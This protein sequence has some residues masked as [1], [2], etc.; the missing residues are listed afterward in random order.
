MRHMLVLLTL[1]TIL[2]SAADAAE[3]VD[4]LDAPPSRGFVSTRPA[5][6]WEKALISGNGTIGALLMSRPLEETIIF[7]HEPMVLVR[8]FGKGRSVNILLGHDAKAMATPA[9]RTLMRRS[10][11]WAATGDVKS[12][13]GINKEEELKP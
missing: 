3:I 10:V 11:V 13:P 7:S 9:F 12:E 2:L 1:L 5:D 8:G 6:R 4:P